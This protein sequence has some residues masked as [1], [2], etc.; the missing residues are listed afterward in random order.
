MRDIAGCNDVM[1][2]GL[3]YYSDLN[4]V[5]MFS[6]GESCPKS[7]RPTYKK[8]VTTG[9]LYLYFNIVED[10]SLYYWAISSQPCSSKTYT[11]VYRNV[12]Y[13]ELIKPGVW[14][15]TLPDS[16]IIQNDH[17]NLECKYTHPFQELK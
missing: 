14:T 1:V 10:S 16:T 3:S 8:S 2:S 17:V 13:I 12:Y 6:E 7:C 11:R 15:E 4:G 5:Y 9:E